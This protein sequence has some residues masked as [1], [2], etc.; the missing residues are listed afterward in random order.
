MISG[1]N[2]GGKS[3]SLCG[4]C[5]YHATG[6]YPENWPGRKWKKPITFAI[7]G[8]TA[9]STRD[10]L[11]DRLLGTPENRGG[12]Y[13]PAECF[14]PEEDITRM[15]GGVPNQIESF[16]VKHYTNGVHDGYSKGYVFAYSAGWQRLAGYTLNEIFCDEEMDFPIYD[17]FSARLNATRGH[18][19]ISMTPLLG[20]TD[21]YLLFERAKKDSLR[22]IIVFGVN[23]AA[24]LDAEHRKFL[25][26]K[27][28]NHP[29]AEARLH[30]RPI[31]GKGLVF[32][33]PDELMVVDD[34]K[35]P[36]HW[37]QLIG[38]DFPH[39][40]GCFAAAKLAINPENGFIYLTGEYKLDGQ[41]S[42]VYASRVR[43]MGGD[44]IPCAWPHDA[45][46]QFTSGATVAERYRD[47]G[48]HMLDEYSHVL[49]RDGKKTHAIFEAIEVL[50]D[51][52]IGGGFY[53]F[54]SCNGFLDEKRKYRHDKGKIVRG[55]DDHLIDAVLK[56]IFML[57]FA[58]VP[59][60][61]VQRV[62]KWRTR[63]REYDF[64]G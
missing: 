59:G 41:A 22:K 50:L 10:L 38:L 4:K 57:R 56:G 43:A 28:E 46:R 19:S 15:P 14:D 36:S 32:T 18:L 58:A 11:V 54:K 55:Q 6:L 48:L 49:T 27:Y 33:V 63:V 16:R 40:T 1:L 31:R 64:F 61:R 42:E 23:D 45:G 52:M 20:E 29:L 13:I 24:H 60:R 51:K 34:F 47:L 44:A 62:D 8:E 26:D 30:G 21:L 53:V 39:T 35:V 7:G 17:E 25:M 2:Q 3:T 5:A 12:G 37:P 9:S